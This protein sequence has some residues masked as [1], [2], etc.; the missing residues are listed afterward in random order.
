MSQPQRSPGWW[1]P[2]IYVGV[3]CVVVAIN[4]IMVYIAVTTFSGL[5]TEDAYDKGVAYNQQIAE[6]QR[7]KE[8]GWHL[9]LT[10]TPR[11]G[12][13][14]G[15]KASSQVAADVALSVQDASGRPV[16]GLTVEAE[17]RRP[18]VGGFDQHLVLADHG[19]GHYDAGA[20]LPLR[21][22]WDVLIVASRSDARVHLRQR[23]FL[24]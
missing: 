11:L 6:A 7:E 12:Q 10:V 22:Q 8:L 24:P 17:V 4:G 9:A 2:Y 3:F 15:G 14:A 18:S 16:N 23:A 20:V 19:G 5:A 13:L 1:Y 21:G